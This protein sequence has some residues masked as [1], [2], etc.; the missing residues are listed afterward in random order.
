M[1]YMIDGF[2]A[3]KKVSLFKLIDRQRLNAYLIR[4]E[5]FFLSK[6]KINDQ[7]TAQYDRAREVFQVISH[8]SNLGNDCNYKLY[9]T[10]SKTMR[11]V[12]SPFVVCQVVLKATQVYFPSLTRRIL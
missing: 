12:V 6:G 2:A 10:S 9:G 5:I 4:K 3:V 7:R 8:K 1:E 11:T